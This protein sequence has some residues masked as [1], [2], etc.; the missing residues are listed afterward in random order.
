MVEP[1]VGGGL[2]RDVEDQGSLQVLGKVESDLVPEGGI[3]YGTLLKHR[4]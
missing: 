4:W 3:H 2:V 1:G